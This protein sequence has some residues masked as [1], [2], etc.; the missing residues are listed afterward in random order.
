MSDLIKLKSVKKKYLLGT[1][2][3]NALRGVDLIIKRGE[4]TSIM[5]PSGS[6]KST[7]M[8]IMGCLDT[9]TEGIYYLDGEKVSDFDDDALAEIRKKK[10]GFVFQNF[11]LLPRATILYNVSLPMIYAGVSLSERKK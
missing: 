7:L 4:F 9:P 10:I 6:G 8:H 11:Y 3:V 1:T 2:E 5:G